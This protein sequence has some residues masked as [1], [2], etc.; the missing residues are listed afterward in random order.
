ML[1]VAHW[2]WVLAHFRLPIARALREHGAEVVLVSPPGDAVDDLRDAGF[3]WVHWDVDRLGAAP[4][5]E[6][7]AVR[8]LAA[9]YR[10]EQPRAVQHFTLKPVLYGSLAAHRAR[11]PT[12]LNVF[13]GLGYVF[14]DQGRRLRRVLLP[15][16]R[17]AGHRPTTW[18]FALNAQ[19]LEVLRRLRIAPVARSGLLPEGVDTA[20]FRPA[21][22]PRDPDVPVALLAARLLR[23]KGVGE[24]VAA[25]RELQRRGASI[26][27][28]IAGEPDD[29]NPTS[30]PSAD[31]RRWRD[32]G[33]AELLGRREDVDRL[34]READIAVLPTRYKEGLPWFLL[35]AA[36]TGLPLVATDVPGC[37]DVVE[38]EVT[39]LTVPTDAPIA[40]ADALERLAAEPELR[41]RLGSA[42]HAHVTAH[43]TEQRVVAEHVAHYRRLGVLPP[44]AAGAAGAAEASGAAAARAPATPSTAGP[45]RTA[46]TASR[47]ER[48]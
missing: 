33:A 24:L 17:W 12:V 47:R 41:R 3:R 10:R 43:H 21:D 5:R 16:L 34:L 7:A 20:R 26:R 13:S 9:I 27:V 30:V 48:T 22:P 42:A 25:A 6:L 14:S 31:L 2:D 15:P 23:D 44:A 32:E 28:R 19:D 8:R 45:T 29:G 35:E 38:H 36:A 18:T 46:A 37:R 40:L 11:V 39:G 4:H 1:L